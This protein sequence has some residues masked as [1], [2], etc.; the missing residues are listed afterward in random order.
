MSEKIKPVE[1][2]ACPFC[3][4]QCQIYTTP[5]PLKEFT[6]RC[7]LC[8]SI[9]MSWFNSREAAISAWNTRAKEQK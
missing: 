5:W 6:P 9:R 2:L 3:G 7:I 4:G 8:D 1:L